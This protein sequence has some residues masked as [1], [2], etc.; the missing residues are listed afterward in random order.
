MKHAAQIWREVEVRKKKLKDLFFINNRQ[1]RF[2]FIR[3]EEETEMRFLYRKST[4]HPHDN[5]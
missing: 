1:R 4:K 3:F 2:F 5:E